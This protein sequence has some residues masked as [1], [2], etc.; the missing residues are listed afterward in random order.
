M[1][2]GPAVALSQNLRPAPIRPVANVITR[3]AVGQLYLSSR[4][5]MLW[6]TELKGFGVRCRPSG[7][8]QYFLKLR[9]GG[10]QRWLT[11]GRHGSIDNI[12]W[13][14]KKARPGSCSGTM[15]WEG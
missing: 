6:E 8:K 9:V 7:G 4:D 2:L 12:A 11:I 13:I 10:R 1:R 3:R 5:V 14:A 15:A